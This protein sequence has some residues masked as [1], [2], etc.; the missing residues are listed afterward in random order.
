V[1][2]IKHAKGLAYIAHFLAHPGREF[3]VTELVP[4]FDGV[5][6]GAANAK[7]IDGFTRTDLGD[8][9]P[10]LDAT[11]KLSYRRRLRDLRAELDEAISIS[12]S[13]RAERAREE[14]EFLSKELARA[15]GI[16]GRDR[17]INSESE[18]ARLRVTNAVRAALRKI[19]K[20]HPALGRYLALSLHTGRLCSF[21]PDARFPG[22]WRI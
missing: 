15:V 14:I 22:A 19:T 1:I 8:T 21:E 16:G 7:S 11:S 13:G 18:R 3:H 9:G 2:R 4:L 10:A 5:F 6:G 17:K 20:E 12:D